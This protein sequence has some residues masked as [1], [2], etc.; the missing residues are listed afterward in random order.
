MKQTF[1]HFSRGR[2]NTWYVG[3]FLFLLVSFLATSSSNAQTWCQATH[4]QT[5]TYSYPVIGAVNFKQ[6]SKTLFSKGNDGCNGGSNMFNVITTTPAFTL[7]AGSS[8]T[9]EMGMTTYYS[10]S[11]GKVGAWIDLNRDGDFADAGEFLSQG[12]ADYPMLPATATNTFTISCANVSPGTTRLRLRSTPSYASPFNQSEACNY[13]YEG[14]TEDYTVTLTVPS[15]VSADF[16]T[17]DTAFVGTVVKFINSNQ[18]GYVGHQWDMDDNG[19]IE[20]YNTDFSYVFAS[21]STYSLRLKSQNCKGRD[22]IVKNIVVISPTQKPVAD[23]LSDK[24]VVQIY[25]YFTLSDLSENGPTYWKWEIFDPNTNY[26]L[27]PSSFPELEGGDPY[28]NQNPTFYIDQEGSYTVC[29]NST[30]GVDSSGRVCKADYIK[31][32]SQNNIWWTAEPYTSSPSG[33]LFDQGGPNGNYSNNALSSMVIK[34]CGASTVSINFS[35]FKLGTGE[36]FYIWDGLDASGIPL[37]P[38]G[39]FTMNSLVDKR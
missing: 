28:M 27:D 16:Y 33:N 32:T 13:R 5:C 22:S 23:F 38:L 17:P 9:L 1:T 24:N 2:R 36:V 30:N 29:L 7:S 6:G 31:V 37:H 4:G 3:S 25:D 15:T 11:T 35:Q 10:Y 26:S 12:W 8:Y 34:P 18:N 20:S 39:G 21:P 14:E 19:S